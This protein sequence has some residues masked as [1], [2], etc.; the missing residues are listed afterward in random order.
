MGFSWT[1]EL[2]SSPRPYKVD[3]FTGDQYALKIYRRARE[4]DEWEGEDYDGTSVLAGAKAVA[5]AGYIK[6][7]RWA[8]STEQ[9][10]DAIISEGPVVIG[11]N[12]YDSMYET[13]SSGLV[14]VNGSPVGGH[15]I[16][17]TGYNPRARLVGEKGYRELFRWKNSWG[18]GYGVKGTGYVG[19]EDLDMLLRER[20]EACV[21]MQRTIVRF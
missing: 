21:P 20:G 1:G 5:E 3:A 18:L 6:E 13:R 10:R 15:A 12:W 7:Y 8:F 2:I 19:I 9:V 16:V 4:L 11:I 14:E 17:L